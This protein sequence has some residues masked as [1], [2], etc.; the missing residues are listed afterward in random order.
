MGV[1]SGI[2]MYDAVASAARVKL[3]TPITTTASG[4]K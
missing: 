3:Q 1:G 2:Y 4:E